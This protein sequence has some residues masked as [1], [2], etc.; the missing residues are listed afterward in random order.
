M[1]ICSA[2]RST[3]KTRRA[4][5]AGWACA[6]GVSDEPGETVGDVSLGFSV[7]APEGWSGF[8]RGNYQFSDDLEAIAGS[9]GLRYAW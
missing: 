5:A 3:S 6:F 9:A 1:S 4:W 7:A 2:A 8:L